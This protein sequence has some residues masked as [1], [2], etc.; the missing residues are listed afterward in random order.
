MAAEPQTLYPGV[1]LHRSLASRV[2]LDRNNRTAVKV[3]SPPA[4]VKLLYWLA[5]QAPFPYVH[6]ENALLAARERRRIAGLLTRMWYGRD[7]VSPVLTIEHNDPAYAYVTRLVEGQTPDRKRARAFL[8]DLASRFQEVGLPVWQINP[9]NPKA[10][11]NLIETPDGEYIVIDLESAVVSPMMPPGQWLDALR[12]GMLPVFDDLFLQRTRAYV[13]KYSG[14]IWEALGEEGLAELRSAIDA[15]EEHWHAW[16]RSEL[17]LW[18]RLFTGT[19][20]VVRGFARVLKPLWL[21]S[22]I[23]SLIRTIRR[24]G[25]GEFVQTLVTKGIAEWKQEGRLDDTAAKEIEGSLRAPEVFSALRHLSAHAAMSVPL[26]FP[27]GSLARA[28]WTLAFRAKAEWRA[29]V[30]RKNDEETRSARRTHTAAV[31][32]IAAVPGVGGAAYLAAEPLRKN[33]PV[34]AVGL[35]MLLRKTPARVYQRLHLG[36]LTRWLALPGRRQAKTSAR[37]LPGRLLAEARRH[38]APVAAVLG[39]SVAAVVAGELAGGGNGAFGEWGPITTFRVA[40]TAAAG[41][42]GL[43]VYRLF[44]RRANAED[45]VDAAAGSFFW[46]LSGAGMLAL[47]ADDYLQVHERVGAGMDA[48]MEMPLLN[49]GGDAILLG[50]GITAVMVI[51]VF[52]GELTRSPVV[53]ALLGVGA[54]FGA[55]SLAI[56]LAEPN[57]SA[58]TALGHFA[59]VM[60]PGFLLAAVIVKYRGLAEAEEAET[61]PQLAVPQWQASPV[62]VDFRSRSGTA[63]KTAGAR[64]AAAKGGRS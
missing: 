4:P 19:S 15:Y 57:G 28:G 60:G 47:A 32:L 61:V 13:N 20:A 24:A 31:A 1:T 16:R 44:W 51:A 12:A 48:V 36:A 2:F 55:L 21:P 41:I 42:T 45:D 18:A 43:L 46:L 9:R 53:A 59:E 34:L 26:R 35:D 62:S 8:A 6:N 10:H 17:R 63:V 33:R 38:Q 39:A 7:L 64:Q 3:Y 27:I 49:A 30:L 52:R 37:E 25:E 40:G 11:E 23:P 56:E 14:V 54:G 5:F 22:S 29:I 50:Y 58:M